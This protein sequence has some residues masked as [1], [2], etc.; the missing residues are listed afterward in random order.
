VH[1]LASVLA[2]LGANEP[3]ETARR[4]LERFGSLAAFASADAS[5][6]KAA[7][8]AIPAL[9]PALAA[10]QEIAFAAMKERV[11][12]SPL[13]PYD[14]PF[15]DYLRL[16]LGGRRAEVLLGFFAAP[17]GMLLSEQKLAESK[18]HSLAISAAAILREAISLG[19]AKVLMVHNHPSGSC[20][21]SKADEQST[22]ELFAR[23]LAVDIALIDHLVV[24]GGDIYSIRR[25][26][27]L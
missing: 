21:A 13:N 25:G 26:R 1:Y 2:G 15:L 17:D 14:P 6:L 23:G 4:I 22:K 16:S 10:A 18:G 5:Q 3:Q 9:P 11:L 27:I 19:A 24:G 20:R 8:L 7:L 12:T